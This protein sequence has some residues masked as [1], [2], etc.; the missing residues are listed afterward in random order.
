M[1]NS[2]II[3]NFIW[4]FAEKFGAQIIAFFVS[5]VL[6]RVLDPEDYGKVA[7]VAVF[8]T[9]LAVFCD[10]GL[11]NSLIQKI[12]ADDKDFSTVLFFNVVTSVLMC[13]ALHIVAPYIALYYDDPELTPLIRFL[14]F[15]LPLYGIRNVQQAYVSKNMLFKKFFF[16]TV[17]G[18][19][20]SAVVGIG[21]A[22]RGGG[23]WALVMMQ[24]SN[25]V[26]DTIILWFTVGWKPK[27][28]FSKKRLGRLFSYGGRILMSGVMET[29]YAN[30][31]A[32]IIGKIYTQ[33]T[34]A[35]YTKGRNLPDLIGT[36]INN[37]IEIVMF[38]VLSKKQNNR[39]NLR[40]LTKKT[41][42]I[43]TVVLFPCFMG[44]IGIADTLV[45]T[46][47]G[48]KWE[49]AV[50][51][52]RLFCVYF[53]LFPFHT[54]NLNVIKAL[55]RSDI[56]LKQEV[57]KKIIGICLLLL[58]VKY[59]VLAMAF[60]LVFEGLLA[61]IVNTLPNRDLIKYGYRDQILDNIPCFMVAVIMSFCVYLGGK[62]PVANPIKLIIQIMI[63][64]VVYIG[65]IRLIDRE[66]YNY[67][68]QFLLKIIDKGEQ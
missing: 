54:S 68:L 59:G 26:M 39:N 11:G 1:G 19:I 17:I 40:E 8:T 2:R 25:Q 7:I 35:F 33:E 46:V 21:I 37:S 3:N 4:K 64:I 32:L 67:V 29:I 20:V 41:I 47:Y 23:P 15:S 30:L 57:V 10:C 65:G 44:F 50:P 53:M 12:D 66:L 24:L 22:M 34:L 38:P 6:A 49:M 62:M 9:I 52:M 55:G 42:K 14:S 63:G 45:S 27:V 16:S 5:V 60:S 28:Y 51:Y 48:Q 18:T 58:T 43:S 13:G 31:R 36:N 61:Q 56:I